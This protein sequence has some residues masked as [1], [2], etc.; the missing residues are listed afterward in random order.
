MP[1]DRWDSLDDKTKAIWDSIEDKF[2]DII[3]GYTTSSSHTSSFTPHHG[4]TPNTSFN[5]PSSKSRK[6]LL[7]EFLEAFGDELEE[8]PEEAIAD[9]VPLSAADLEPDPPADLLINAAKG[10][11][12]MPLPPGDIR[13]VMSR[14]SKRSVHTVCIEYKVSYHKE[15]RGISPSLVDRGANG[16]VTGNDV[17]VIFKPIAPL[18]LKA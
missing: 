6:A 5:R 8:S 14:N 11:N 15:H 10:S 17:R 7:H 12:S 16:G 9:D 2:K 18:T 4:N 1:R 3:L 13:R